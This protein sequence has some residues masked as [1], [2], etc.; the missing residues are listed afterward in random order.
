MEIPRWRRRQRQ[1]LEN[2]VFASIKAF[3]CLAYPFG[4][5]INYAVAF[6]EPRF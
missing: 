3:Q 5:P 1:R 2:E 6:K 4:A